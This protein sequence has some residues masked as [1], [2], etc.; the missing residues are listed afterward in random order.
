MSTRQ[1]H[2]STLPLCFDRNLS[3]T[4][5][6]YRCLDVK[7]K[8]RDGKSQVQLRR[9]RSQAL[10][11]RLR[12]VLMGLHGGAFLSSGAAVAWYGGALP[13]GE[14]G[15]VVVAPNNRLGDA[16]PLEDSL[17]GRAQCPA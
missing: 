16:D 4:R 15:V 2:Y 11:G 3:V 1:N 12:Q 14:G 10:Y 17:P 13:T 5:Q 7:S 9:Q 8:A 6:G